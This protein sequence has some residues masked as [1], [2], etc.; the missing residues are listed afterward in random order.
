MKKLQNILIEG[1][2]NCDKL[3]LGDQ[4][5]SVILTNINNL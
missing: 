4:I 5:K 3:L 2:R 1:N